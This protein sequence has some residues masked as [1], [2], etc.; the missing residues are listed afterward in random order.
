MAVAI[1][2]GYVNAWNNL[3]VVLGKQCRV[4]E[5]ILAC[6]RVLDMQPSN[7]QALKI[8]ETAYQTAGGTRPNTN[9]VRQQPLPT[10]LP[11]EG[12]TALSLEALQ[13]SFTATDE[14]IATIERLL[15]DD[16]PN[17]ASPCRVQLPEVE[18]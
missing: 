18:Y 15:A 8:I 10:H 3:A 1:S 14:A 16:E 12:P 11:D 2:P 17:Y 5:A 13:E 7:A 6:H 9:V 4:P